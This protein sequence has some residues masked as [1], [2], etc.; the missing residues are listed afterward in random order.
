MIV[1]TRSMKELIKFLSIVIFI[2]SV[3]F[4]SRGET[5]ELIC[6]FT[7]E[8][9]LP[10]GWTMGKNVSFKNVD[11]VNCLYIN[12][13][14]TSAESRSIYTG[15]FYK[16]NKIKISVKDYYSNKNSGFNISFYRPEGGTELCGFAYNNPDT[17]ISDCDVE[18]KNGTEYPFPTD[19]I[20]Y[21]MGISCTGVAI[22]CITITYEE[23]PEEEENVT[24]FIF[25]NYYGRDSENISGDRLSANNV[26][27][28]FSDNVTYAPELF[29]AEIVDG[30]CVQISADNIVRVDIGTPFFNKVVSVNGTE[31]EPYEGNGV[32][33]SR[34][35]GLAN[36]VKITP[37]DGGISS[38]TAVAVYTKENAVTLVE[39]N[40][41][42]IIKNGVA[43]NCYEIGLPLQGVVIGDEGKLYARTVSDEAC[44]DISVN[45][46]TGNEYDDDV[47]DFVQRD[48]IAL[49]M[50]GVD[51][52]SASNYLGKCLSAGIIGVLD[53]EA[54]TPTLNVIEKP[55]IDL[56]WATDN[57]YNTYS[58]RNFYGDK[59]TGAFVVKPQINEYAYVSGNIIDAG[60]DSYAISDENGLLVLDNARGIIADSF[61]GCET[62]VEGIVQLTD[63]TTKDYKFYVLG[64]C[65]IE[66]TNI[67]NGA[68]NKTKIWGNSGMLEVSGNV[69]YVEIFNMSGHKIGT[70]QRLNAKRLSVPLHPGF[71]LVK[72]YFYDGR[73]EIHKVIVSRK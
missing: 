61:I 34:W 25:R 40:L 67:E 32:W 54:P 60:S 72:A 38:I 63:T 17:G 51:N 16:I 69:C 12:S 64:V 70:F 49:D 27:I 20:N 65:K 50:S 29:Y 45:N 10:D 15:V 47:N 31:L 43:G 7:K 52:C 59:L 9:S 14:N 13:T 19:I 5:R 23:R 55:E 46:T 1:K 24:S 2:F 39:N 22:S 44:T 68:E 6:D 41:S 30:E 26:E 42:G 37:P 53:T 8:Q 58:V 18:F 35:D 57:R 3:A 11:G 56:E 71:Y 48:W 28:V 21:S 62:T 66:H 4:P 73:I 36:R 33:V